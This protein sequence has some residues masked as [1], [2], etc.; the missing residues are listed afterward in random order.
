MGA[1]VLVALIAIGV[2]FGWHKLRGT[3]GLG[4]SARSWL[5]PA[6]VVA[7]VILLMWLGNVG[8]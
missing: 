7:L 5:G 4:R 2:G 1:V 6:A 8:R 3:V